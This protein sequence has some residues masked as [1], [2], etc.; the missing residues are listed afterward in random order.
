MTT[1]AASHPVT[2]GTV[3]FGSDDMETALAHGL[4]SAGI[5]TEM[6]RLV[7][8]LDAAAAHRDAAHGAAPLL[9]PDV[10]GVLV[11]A[12]GTE[13]ALRAAARSTAENPGRTE[14]V[15]LLT[16][17]ITWTWQPSIDLVVDEHWHGTIELELK[18]IFDIAEL[19]AD[20]RGGRLVALESGDCTLTA[21]LSAEGHELAKRT[22]HL[23]LG[24]TV[25][26]G[27]DGIPLVHSPHADG[28]TP[29]TSGPSWID[30]AGRPAVVAG[31][32]ASRR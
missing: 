22:A 15:K 19:D 10:F 24:V 1:V 30:V 14:H 4:R 27:A 3:L 29:V 20:V 9:E 7:G 31:P 32:A 21:T 12:W 25:P 16:Q 2:V 11:A 18:L 26:L 23:D 17:Q 5:L 6:L 13:G 28:P 8:G